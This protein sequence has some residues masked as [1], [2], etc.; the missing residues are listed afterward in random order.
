[1]G[2]SKG[3]K[4]SF[5]PLDA[6]SLGLMATFPDK[7]TLDGIEDRWAE[8]WERDGV[9]R[10]DRAAERDQVFAVDTPPPTV[11]GSIHM[12]TVFGYTQ[13]DS[14]ARYQR[15]RGKSVFFPIGWDD[16]GLATERRVQNYYG[17]RCDPTQQ[18]Q[19]D[20]VPPFRGD[21]PK[22]HHEVP[23]SRRNFI[24]LCEELTA[25]D[26]AVFEELFRRLGMSFDWSLLYTTVG[27]RSRRTSQ[28]AFLHNLDRGEAY[29]ADAPTVW[30]VD[31]RT[32]VAQAEIEDR[33][34]PGAYHL[35]AFQS[36]DGDVLID[37]TRPE[38]IVSCV[39][40]VAHPDDERYQPAFG[41]TVRTP[42]FGVE[43]PIVGHP[44]AQPDKGT[45][46]AMVCTFGDTTDV[47][48]WRELNLP[49]R[50]VIGRDGRL[51]SSMPSWL[52][53]EAG[54]AAYEPLAGRTVKQAQTAMVEAL[55][56]S[57]DLRGDPR[58]IT[59]PVKFYERG[60]RPLEIVTSRQ[61]YIRNGGR[62]TDRRDAFLARGKELAWYPDHMRHRYENWVEGLNGDWLI[63]R[64][65]FFGVPIPLW[66]SVD[67]HGEADYDQPIAPDPAALPIDPSAEAPPGYTEDQR[68]E[69]G[70]FVGDADIM[71]T[72]ATSSLTPQIAGGWADEP[73]LFAHLFP[74]DVRPQG[75]DIIRTWLFSTVVR[76]HFEHGS[77]PWT[78]TM[79]NG[80]ILDPD[81]KKMSKSKG[82]VVTPMGFF[83]QYG[84]DAVRYWSLA[85]RPGVDTAFSEDQMKVGRRLATKL[86]NV[87]KFVLGIEG[88]VDTDTEFDPIDHAMLAQLDSVIVEATRAF[89][90]LDYARAL[91]RTEEFFWWF[92]DDY[93]ELVKGRAYGSRGD[94]AAFSARVALR[95]ALDIV[96]RL[97]APVLPFAT[98][99]CWSWWHDT[100]VHGAD[101]PTRAD[102]DGGRSDPSLDPVSEVLAR[103][104][105][106]KTEAKLSQ[107]AAVARLEVR[108]PVGWISGIEPARHDLV[109]ALTVD[110][111]TIESAD[112]VGIAIQLT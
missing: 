110:Q 3:G 81:R 90:G 49:T 19:A 43:V 56:E 53:T 10:F 101:W 68:G 83:E 9:Y 39:A 46:I 84:T 41:S 112:Q 77:L 93:V 102:D 97:L 64:Q 92:C 69:P 86:L 18:F 66:Y 13:F 79:I 51:T 57:G 106:A 100:S 34:R 29:S 28:L 38:L 76:S 4:A 14:V 27:E 85:A 52:E 111:L 58:P 5:P 107:R 16:N 65:R 103:V 15:M 47:T 61:W 32:A 88:S 104:R 31:D 70:G 21:T 108:G 74:M 73:E 44:L 80:W 99:E 1:M 62:D 17:V 24:D 22:D 109:E 54:R 33:E 87:S 8:R 72:W 42:L 11:S 36:A 105:R 60:S 78:N 6:P 2:A 89:E 12:G 23:I 45:G 48:W 25:I 37:T 71:D 96:Q 30:D 67:E 50:S 94:D 75:P 63:S 55:R 98:E 26:E 82:N 35:I 91:E 20:F 40:L 59:H 95:S 7:P